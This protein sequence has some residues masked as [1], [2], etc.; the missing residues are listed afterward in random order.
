MPHVDSCYDIAE[1]KIIHVSLSR[2]SSF[3]PRMTTDQATEG[4][5][6]THIAQK[7]C[8]FLQTGKSDLFW[9]P[10]IVTNLFVWSKLDFISSLLKS[11]N[12]GAHLSGFQ[13][14]CGMKF[15]L[16]SIKYSQIDIST[17]EKECSVIKSTNWV[18]IDQILSQLYFAHCR[19]ES[20][21]RK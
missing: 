16:R 10:S 2:K 17:T 1:L 15:S 6:Q 3:L 8:L 13:F 5:A 20:I 18:V 14:C 9:N 7:I 12:C 11:I 19:K 21:N 4:I